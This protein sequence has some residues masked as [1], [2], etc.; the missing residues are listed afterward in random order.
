MPVTKWQAAASAVA[1]FAAAELIAPELSIEMP[2]STVCAATSRMPARISSSLRRCWPASSKLAG[3]S[4]S[5]Y[6]AF[7]RGPFGV[8]NG[9]SRVVSRLLLGY[10]VLTKNALG[11]EAEPLGCALRRLVAVVAFPFAAAVAEVLEGVPHEQIVRL[12]RGRFASRWPVPGRYGESRCGGG[13]FY[14]HEGLPNA[15]CPTP[16][17]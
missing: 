6:G 16:Y 9:I 13:R 10:H 11:F 14:A 2:S 12:G 4:H 17:R 15:A 5:W 8:D 7:Q 1:V 3:S